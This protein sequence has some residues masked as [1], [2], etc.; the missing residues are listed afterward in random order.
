MLDLKVYDIVKIERKWDKRAYL[1]SVNS[2]A[3][4][5]E[6]YHFDINYRTLEIISRID[7]EDEDEYTI[8][9]VWRLD[10]NGNYMLIWENGKELKVDNK[11]YECRPSDVDYDT[12][13]EVCKERDE[14]K[15]IVVEQAKAIL[16]LKQ[17]LK[18]KED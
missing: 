15:E 11:P 5:G 1:E 12:H 4:L 18:Y 8:T 13:S 14:L 10:K 9:N 3:H 7:D 2:I 16:N 17:S 6:T